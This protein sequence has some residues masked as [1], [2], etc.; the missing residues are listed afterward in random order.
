MR[1]GF[2]SIL[3]EPVLGL[4][5]IVLPIDYWRGREFAYACTKLG[6]PAGAT[7]L[8]LGSPKDLA[9]Y[10]AR[11][12]GYAVTAVDILREAIDL[13][14][15]TAR[16][17]GLDGKGPGRVSSEVQDGR[18]LPYLSDTF[19]AAYSVSVLEHIPGDGDSVALAELIRVV[20]PG[21][22]V[23]VTTPFSPDYEEVFL[24][25]QVYDREYVPGGES[26]FFER[27]Y[28]GPTLD[29]KLLSVP[30]ARLVNLELWGEQGIRAFHLLGK[31]GRGRDLVSPLE[32]VMSALFLRQLSEGHGHPM[33]VFFTLEVI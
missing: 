33:A 19:D 7:V 28:D 21:G 10:L 1:L 30:G 4:K 9:L 8:D 27:H 31:L 18:A 6:A 29:R 22:R 15:R 3:R 23:V 25:Q 14:R 24:N 12:R 26:V 20:R 5:R 32:G 11:Y 16:A 13:S 17:N 2:G